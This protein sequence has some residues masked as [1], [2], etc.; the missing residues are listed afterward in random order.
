MRGVRYFSE[1]SLVLTGFC[2]FCLTSI[3]FV[4]AC[5]SQKKKTC[6]GWW[7]YCILIWVRTQIFES[8]IGWAASAEYFTIFFCEYIRNPEFEKPRVF[9]LDFDW[10]SHF[11]WT[12]PSEIQSWSLDRHT[13]DQKNPKHPLKKRNTQEVKHMSIVGLLL[14]MLLISP[15][16][17][18]GR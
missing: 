11:H 14:F 16:M 15:K 13:R 2:W 6:H 8:W 9:Y 12:D 17:T 5:T 3:E 7:T 4:R 1:L 10:L 18:I